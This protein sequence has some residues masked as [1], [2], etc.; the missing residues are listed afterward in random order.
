VVDDASVL[1]LVETILS[2]HGL[3]VLTE[4]DDQ[5]TLAAAGNHDGPIELLLC[6]LLCPIS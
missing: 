4:A 3:H 5:I 6:L 2:R 1:R